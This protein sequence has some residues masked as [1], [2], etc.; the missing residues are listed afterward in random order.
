MKV[1]SL[2]QEDPLEEEMAT[3]SSILAWKIPWTEEPGGLQFMGSRRVRH[4]W[5]TERARSTVENKQMKTGP[6]VMCVRL[7]LIKLMHLLWPPDATQLPQLREGV[8]L[9]GSPKWMASKPRGTTRRP[10]L[11]SIM[12]DSELDIRKWDWKQGATSWGGSLRDFIGKKIKPRT[13]AEI[14]TQLQPRGAEWGAHRST[15]NT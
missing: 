11:N 6:L 8:L 4:D 10:R 12:G 9:W 14:I 2:G 13:T 15:S 1:Q 7:F 5:V 3:L